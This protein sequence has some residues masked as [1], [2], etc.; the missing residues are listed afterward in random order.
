MQ[1]A[2]SRDQVTVTGIIFDAA[3]G[4]PLPYVN[5]HLSGKNIGSVS[6]ND[7][8]FLFR[9]PETLLDDSLIISHIGYWSYTNTIC[10]LKDTINIIELDPEPVELAGVVAFPVTGLDIIK[11]AILQLPE[12]CNRNPYIMT[13]FY[14]ELIREKQ[15]LHKYAEGVIR[16]YREFG[17]GDLIKLIKG[18]NRENLKAFAVH[19]NA[20]PTLGGPINCFYRDIT[21]YAR[22]FFSEEYF[23]YY[24]YSLE[25]MTSVDNRPVYIISFD[26]KPDAKK[27][28]YRG[29]LF[30]ERDSKAIIK[31]DYEYN[32]YGLKKSQ[33]D[34]VQ[35]SLAKL[36]VG[37]TFESAGSNAT[38]DYIEMDGQWYLKSVR[39]TIVDKLTRKNTVYLYTTEKELLISGITTENLKAF[40]KDELL[41]P[42]KEFSRQVGE[43]DEEFWKDYTIIKAT[44]SQRTLIEEM[45]G[46]EAE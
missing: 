21:N 27:G 19:K 28:S 33:P 12:N 36:F 15:D 16:I 17:K 2:F 45:A 42:D 46:D 7:G 39:Y 38:V 23:D 13:G 24:D 20:D 4:K 18:R 5:I 37:I 8:Y 40:E 35:R 25:G 26:K 11:A 43:Y 22:E 3:N 32:E 41:D 6:N 30:I 1:T 10:E 31:A 34:P 14:R 9:C 44:D 29:R